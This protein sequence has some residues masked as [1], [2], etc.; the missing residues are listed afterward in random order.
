MDDKKSTESIGAKETGTPG[1]FKQDTFKV[2][3]RNG[4]EKK[5]QDLAAKRNK[6]KEL[7]TKITSK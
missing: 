6:A 2:A 4:F 5:K 3:Y 1:V 7:A